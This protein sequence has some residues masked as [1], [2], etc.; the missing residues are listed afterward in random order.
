MKVKKALELALDIIN[1]RN[2][3]G[4]YASYTADYE[5]N[6]LSYVNI[7][8][9]SLYELDCRIK[10]ITCNIDEATPRCVESLEDDMVL[11]ETICRG[12]L[13]YGL[14]FMLLLEEEPQRAE[15]YHV[16]YKEECARLEK[17]SAAVR[18]RPITEVY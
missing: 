1:Q 18:R 9:I 10:G 14:A 8:T 16:L 2:E 17:M 11:H 12:I 13:P 3:D 6:V 4:E 5:K 15:R 7:L